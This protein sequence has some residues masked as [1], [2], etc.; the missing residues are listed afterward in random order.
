[1][2]DV[3][4]P[5]NLGAADYWARQV[6]S[7]VKGLEKSQ[8][9]T[10]Q[11][12]AG[13]SR[14]FAASSGDLE[15][16]SRRI[17]DALRIIPIFSQV[18]SRFSGF[19]VNTTWQT[20]TSNTIT[21]PKPGRIIAS[22]RTAVYDNGSVP[23]TGLFQ[24]VFDPSLISSEYGP[25]IPT[26]HNGTD[27]AGGAAS[28]GNPVYAPGDGVVSGKGYD[29]GRGNYITLYH[30]IYAPTSGGITTRYFHFQSPSPLSIGDPV[31]RGSTILGYVGNTGNSFG[32]HLHW[33]TWV[34]GFE[35]SPSG[36]PSM[37]PRSFMI[38]FGGGGSGTLFYRHQSRLLVNGSASREFNTDWNRPWSLSY[39]L[40]GY[41]VPEGDNLVELQ[42]RI[43]GTSG[44]EISA[45][46][47]S[48][49]YLLTKGVFG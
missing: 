6:T 31:T 15:E 9:V 2:T 23:T 36:Y 28:A 33:E 13:D 5:S 7:R 19:G 14:A 35:P 4:P 20:V 27:F 48:Y 11:F 37:D 29:A 38:F 17:E 44:E 26:F 16:K 43:P 39:P 10:K 30:G 18:N 46:I 47:R 41:S 42:V 32:A 34:E 45:D 49:A 25:R 12:L 3:F 8:S 1:M 40:G 22:G 24:W 21:A